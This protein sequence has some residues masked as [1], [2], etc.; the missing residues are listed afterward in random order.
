MDPA[1]FARIADSL[2]QYRRAELKDFQEELGKGPV[3]VLYVDPLPGD[4]VLQ[5]V[6]SSNTT[7]LLGRKGTG[8]STI[9]ARAQSAL[10]DRHDVLSTYIDVKSLYDIVDA[11][12]IPLNATEDLEIDSGVYRAHM[13][14]KAFLGKVLAELINE[15]NPLCDSMS[16]WDR[17]SGK[18]RSFAEL[19]KSLENLHSRVTAPDLDRQELPILQQITR[20]WRTQQQ[21]ETVGKSTLDSGIAA[22]LVGSKVGVHASMADFDKSLDDV[23]TYNEYSDVVLRSFPFDELLSEIQDLVMEGALKRIVVF[24]DDFSE[25]AF[26]DQRVFVDVILSPLNNASKEAVKLKIAGYPGRVYYG[27]IDATKVDTISLDFAV[28]YEDTEVQTMERAAI[29]YATRLLVTRFNAFGADITEFFDDS[30]PFEQHMRLVFETTFNVPRLIGALLHICFLDRVAKGQVVTPQS[31]RL[32]ARKYYETTIS[33]Y[34]DR[35]NRFAL[36]PFENKLDR[37][38]QRQL[39]ES[40]VWEARS[41]RSRINQGSVGGTYFTNV[42]NAPTS[43]FTVST[44]LG[45]VFESLESNFLV[46]K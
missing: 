2:R 46:F 37:Y 19:R 13:L 41:V 42:H 38:N 18:R 23:E 11:N 26:V 20:R 39:L 34:F 33:Q 1:T 25:L 7:F 43:H 14:R 24:F 22:S 32:A 15:I 36:E 45:D 12:D 17:W 5:S 21:N 27:R 6:L 44:A 10:R 31:M 28:L 40:V 16:L 35:M 4:A 30:T 9:F 29:D 8:K 3:D